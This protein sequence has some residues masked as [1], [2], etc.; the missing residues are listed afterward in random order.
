MGMEKQQNRM[1]WIHTI[2]GIFLIFA[3]PMIP[4]IDPITKFGMQIGGIFIGAIYLWSTVGTFWPSLLVIIA[5][6]MTDN[7]DMYTMFAA[8]SDYLPMLMLFCMIFF[9]AIGDC[10]LTQYIGRWFLT[11]K[12]INGHP[13]VFNFM[14]LIAMFAVSAFIDPLMA[15]LVLWPTLYI[16]L[17]EAGYKKED[18]YYKIMIVTTFLAVALGQCTLPFFGG[19]LV[20]L[21]AFEAASGIPINYGMYILF[22]IIT[23]VLILL[24]ATLTIKFIL[25]PDMSKMASISIEQINKNSLP[26]MNLQQKIYIGAALAFLVVAIAPSICPENWEIIG[27]LNRLNLVGFTMLAIAILSLIKVDGKPV[28]DAAKITKEYVMWDL[29]LLVVV[30]VFFSGY[31]MADE[32]GIKPWLV[33]LLTPLFGSHG[34][35]F[36]IIILMVVG[37]LITNVAN[38]AITGAI[39]MQIIV[40]MAPTMG[41]VNPVPLAMLITLMMFLALLTPAAS[42][43]AAVLHANKE[44]VSTADI[45]KYG[46]IMLIMAIFVYLLIG[47]PLAKIMF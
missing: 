19:Q 25:R 27:I 28:L 6:G 24:A 1:Q 21:G 23:S 39:L 41:I 46:S 29:Y 34:Q 10:G 4:P 13:S 33:G 16:I 9:G 7:I 35:M 26:P 14:M 31:L 30:A 44:K 2:I 37:V 42:P 18:S 43:Y 11:R 47:Y 20:I 45:I 32:T 3:I 15:L 22:N 17:E 38:N 5:L 8:F 12:L 40:A 36:F